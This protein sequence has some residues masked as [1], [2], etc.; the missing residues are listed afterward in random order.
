MVA[1]VTGFLQGRRTVVDMTVGAGG[2]AGA[3]LDAG[4]DRVIGVDRDPSAL[5]LA[6]ERLA[7]YGERFRPVSSRF[8]EVDEATVGALVE[9][10]LYDLG[11]SSM[12][13]DRPE[14][15]FGYRV[16]GPLDMRM[17]DDAASAADLVNE[18]PEEEL[19][20]LIFEFGQE[21]RSRRIARRLA[22]CARVLPGSK[23]KGTVRK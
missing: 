23:G 13:L 2:H 6:R 10:V 11:V 1:E 3:L 21:R 14:R 17:G 5:E 12:Q 8:S 15:G 16:D 9:G 18:L 19:A 22:G 7:S 20:N 4:V